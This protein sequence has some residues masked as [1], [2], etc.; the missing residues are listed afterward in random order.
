MIGLDT[1][2]L[3]R[4]LTQDDEAQSAMANRLIESFDPVTPG[5]VSIVTLVETVWVLDRSYGLDRATLGSIV[6]GLLTSKELVLDRAEDVIRGL[7]SYR[8]GNADFSDCLIFSISDRRGCEATM[9]LDA[10]A[11]RTAGM[12]LLAS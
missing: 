9:T 6:N 2:V 8:R 5:F 4:Y 12:T 1:N 10:R 11:A 3:V 7:R